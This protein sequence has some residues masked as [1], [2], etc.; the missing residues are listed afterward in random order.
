MSMVEGG[1]SLGQDRS[2]LIVLERNRLTDPVPPAQ[3]LHRG[4][5]AAV[6]RR[7]RPTC[8]RHVFLGR[9]WAQRRGASADQPTTG[10]LG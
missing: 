8:L 1:T 5:A 9:E 7:S 6:L 10:G 3:L 4:Q 2:R